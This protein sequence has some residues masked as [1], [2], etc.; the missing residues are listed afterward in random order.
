MIQ[1]IFVC[2]LGRRGGYGRKGM[3]LR[4]IGGDACGFPRVNVA[5]GI[6]RPAETEQLRRG[7]RRRSSLGIVADEIPIDSLTGQLVRPI[8]LLA[9]AVVDD[10]VPK[11]HIGTIRRNHS[12][13]AP[14]KLRPTATMVVGVEVMVKR[15]VAVGA[16]GDERTV[17]LA[18]GSALT[19][20]DCGPL[21]RDIVGT[22][23]IKGFIRPARKVGVIDYEIVDGVERDG[24]A[25]LRAD[26]QE[27][28][29]RVVEIRVVVADGAVYE[30]NSSRAALPEDGDVAVGFGQGD[31]PAQIDHA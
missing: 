9:P 18:A 3:R 21:H 7:R 15:D 1:N 31:I 10:V 16:V 29:H 2:L 5:A 12:I 14:V 8:D 17:I 24:V 25:S 13:P 27:S 11:V 19:V 26:P 30:R 4:A 28:K 20:H 22:I 23:D 6:D